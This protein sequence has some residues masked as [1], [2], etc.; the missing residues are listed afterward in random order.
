MTGG[1]TK[2]KER[3]LPKGCYYDKEAGDRAVRFFEGLKHTKG[4][5]RGKPFTLLPWQKK[6]IRE[7][8]GTLKP[9]GT[10]L[11]KTVYIEIPKKNGK[12]ELGAGFA[13]YL[14]IA[15]NEPGAE[16]YSAASDRDQA[17]IVYNV[18]K[19]MV[20]FS[21]ALQKVC[22][23]VDSVK[24]IVNYKNGGFYRVLSSESKTKHG[25]NISGVIFD[26]LHTQ[27]DRR[28]Y[29][30]L[31][32]G[33]GDAREQ[34]LYVF[35]TTAGV[36]RN[37]VCWEVHEKARE[38]LNG[39]REDPEFYPVIYGLDEAEDQQDPELWTKESTWKKVN[40]SLGHIIRMESVRS[41]FKE[42]LENP[43][44]EN[45]FR[46]LRLNQWVKSTIKPIP[47]KIWDACKGN[48]DEGE[49][50]GSDCYG[51]LDLSSSIDL[52]SLAIVFPCG[53]TFK[54]VHRFWIP[55]DTMREAEKR[56][57]V[58]YS[59]WV[60]RGFITATPGN[61][62]DYSYIKRDLLEIREKFELKELAYDRWGAAK[63][64]VDLQEEGFAIDEKEAGPG[65]PLIVGFGQGFKS[66]SPAC[67]ELIRLVLTGKLE[68]G[69]HPVL[70]WNIDNLVLEQDAAENLKPNKA[71]AV[72]RIDGAV[73]LLMALDRAVRHEGE[74]G[75]SMYETQEVKVF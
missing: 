67:K 61:V 41:Q 43:A 62:V 21:P 42:A 24:R 40:P 75:P 48:V 44:K 45:T 25:F 46:Q 34:P 6:I 27:P 70:R 54:S 49:L 23:T 29:D 18:A 60:K 66:M 28:L 47:L 17:A 7:V 10:R 50:A 12:S 15:D 63:L 55:E 64:M 68:H 3:K 74:N 5:W 39:T 59:T 58:P 52:T 35:L 73:A 32:D 33:T 36:D 69:G 1:R 9:D 22:K 56:D 65:H 13:L 72:Q 71:K 26:E 16:V 37:S 2:E 20:E 51:G 38:I 57:K 14:L 30:V 4:R 8:F 11:Y 19:D 31:T 53:D